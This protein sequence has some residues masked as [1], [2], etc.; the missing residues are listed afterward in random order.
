MHVRE[1]VSRYPLLA[2]RYQE[3][4]HSVICTI[5][6]DDALDHAIAVLPSLIQ[7]RRLNAG[8]GSVLDATSHEVKTLL[9]LLSM[10]VSVRCNFA[11]ANIISASVSVDRLNKLSAFHYD[12]I[13]ILSLVS[14][15]CLAAKRNPASQPQMTNTILD[16]LISLMREARLP[17]D[18]HRFEE[19]EEFKI[20]CSNAPTF[21][22][23]VM[24]FSDIRQFERPADLERLR[25]EIVNHAYDCLVLKME[26]M[27]DY[28]LAPNKA[29]LSVVEEMNIDLTAILLQ[30]GNARSSMPLLFLNLLPVKLGTGIHDELGP[31]YECFLAVL[32]LIFTSNVSQLP[33]NLMVESIRAVVIYHRDNPRGTPPECLDLFVVTQKMLHIL[34][35][36]LTNFYHSESLAWEDLFQTCILLVQFIFDPDTRSCHSGPVSPRQYPHSLN[37]PPRLFHGVIIEI[38]NHIQQVSH[39]SHLPFGFAPENYLLSDETKAFLLSI[40]VKTGEFTRMDKADLLGAFRLLDPS[41]PPWP[42]SKEED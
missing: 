10:D 21:A 3:T 27:D 23:L 29:F 26:E 31:N 7:E 34:S 28:P 2:A 13:S 41:L 18:V 30:I 20:L 36:S 14:A 37:S 4:F 11:A 38:L 16:V 24:P 5:H 6:D 39:E 15:L 32:H 9:H 40:E 25:L 33:L 35:N 12:S 19:T 42:L 17:S 8:P 1:G 22:L